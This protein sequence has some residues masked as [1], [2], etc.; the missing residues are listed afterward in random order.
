MKEEEEKK[1]KDK[2][3]VRNKNK[4]ILGKNHVNET[5]KENYEK[6]W[7]KIYEKEMNEKM[8]SIKKE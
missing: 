8:K 7:N 2:D 6:Y 1:M 5:Q 4:K 3:I